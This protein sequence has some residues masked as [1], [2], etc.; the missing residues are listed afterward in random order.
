MLTWHRR[1]F[2]RWRRS[3]R[4]ARSISIMRIGDKLRTGK[5]K[6]TLTLSTG[7]CPRRTNPQSS[8][9]IDSVRHLLCGNCELD[10][11]ANEVLRWEGWISNLYKGFFRLAK[12]LKKRGTAKL[13]LTTEKPPRNV[14]ANASA[15]ESQPHS[16]SGIA[17]TSPAWRAGG[18]SYKDSSFVAFGNSIANR[19]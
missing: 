6:I 11:F 16:T 5:V 17:Q 8:R 9:L 14:R 19:F 2:L 13:S 7:L 1:S 3:Q 12:I 15:R 4:C 18:I 10:I